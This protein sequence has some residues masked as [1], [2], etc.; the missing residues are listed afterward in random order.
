MFVDPRYRHLWNLHAP[1]HHT[2][3]LF[4]SVCFG[5]CESIGERGIPHRLP[6]NPDECKGVCVQ[7]IGEWNKFSFVKT[8]SELV[9]TNYPYARPIT[10]KF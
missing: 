10:F 4:F 7:E 6:G 3:V 1:H 9:K 2:Y 8:V 5:L